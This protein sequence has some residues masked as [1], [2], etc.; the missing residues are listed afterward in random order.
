MRVASRRLRAALPLFSSCFPEKDFRHWM[1]E[2]KSVTRALGEARDTDVQIAFLKK[3][4]KAQA[5]PV[6]ADMTG[7][8]LHNPTPAIPLPHF[9]RGSRNDAG[10]SSSR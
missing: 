3:Y 10:S 5:V 8:P 7:R 9:F 2:I 1:H 6:P 4:L